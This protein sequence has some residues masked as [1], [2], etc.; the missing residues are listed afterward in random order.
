MKKLIFTISAF[1]FVGSS[2]ANAEQVYYCV[3]KL[4]TGISRDKKT[5]EWKMPN[6]DWVR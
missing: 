2:F 1:L 3:D 5:G 4:V 6:F